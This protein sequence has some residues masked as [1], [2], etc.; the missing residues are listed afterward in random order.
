MV[1]TLSHVR[2]GEDVPAFV[3]LAVGAYCYLRAVGRGPW[4]PLHAALVA[5][6]LLCVPDLV[7]LPLPTGLLRGRGGSDVAGCG[8]VGLLCR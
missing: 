4:L 6:P 2:K 7:K 3:L 5:V 8:R 1:S